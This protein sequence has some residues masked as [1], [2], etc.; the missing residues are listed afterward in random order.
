MTTLRSPTAAEHAAARGRPLRL[1]FPPA[2]LLHP[3]VAPMAAEYE[4]LMSDASE[5]N[6]R[7]RALEA[8]RRQAVAADDAA[9][10]AALRAGQKDPG[11]KAVVKV[12]AEIAEAKRRSQ[13]LTRALGDLEGELVNVVG[14]VRGAWLRT[15]E[16]RIEDARKVYARALDAVDLARGDFV[17]TRAVAEWAARFP[18][19]PVFRD[20]QPGVQVAG[21]NTEALG[22]RRLLERLGAEASSGRS[23]Q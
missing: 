9:F 23:G 2:E 18:E 4:R 22:W 20:H 19:R 21:P 15:L 6:G 17:R 14:R 13:A 5:T 16:E 7:L 11:A 8:E 3:D 12:D 1:Q 10:A